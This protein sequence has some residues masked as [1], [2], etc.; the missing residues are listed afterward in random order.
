VIPILAHAAPRP[1]RRQRPIP[2]PELQLVGLHSR[3]GEKRSR[4]RGILCRLALKF[5]VATRSYRGDTNSLS[6]LTL[7]QQR[8]MIIMSTITWSRQHNASQR[9]QLF[10]TQRQNRNMA[11]RLAQ[12]QINVLSIACEKKRLDMVLGLAMHI[13]SRSSRPVPITVL[14]S[15]RFTTK[16]HEL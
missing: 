12:F 8:R 6:R 11:D 14:Q 13:F 16:T 4:H 2:G 5:L 9:F 1:F 10:T 15:S 7:L 3:F